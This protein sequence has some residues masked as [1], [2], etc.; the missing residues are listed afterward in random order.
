MLCDVTR[1]S[2][3]WHVAGLMGG[4]LLAVGA[5]AGAFGLGVAVPATVENP[6]LEALVSLVALCIT[7]VG[8]V[9]AGVH[10]LG[11]MALSQEH[12]A[13]DAARGGLDNAE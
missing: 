10:A 13:P 4:V 7:G 12:E 5:A 2:R 1:R 3:R 9:M 8:A 6:M 11:L